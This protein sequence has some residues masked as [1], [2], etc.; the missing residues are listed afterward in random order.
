MAQAIPHVCVSKKVFLKDQVNWNSVCGAIQGLPWRSIW[1]ADNPVEV[2]DDHLLLLV[3][4]LVPTKVIC[5]S[6]KDKSWFD[7]QCRD[8]CGLKQEAH[9]R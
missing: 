9:L 2:L 6:N 7:D 4:R 5:M 1:S 3:G 8:L